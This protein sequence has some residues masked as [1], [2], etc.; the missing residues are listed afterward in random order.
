MPIV[1]YF[2]CSTVLHVCLSINSDDK[3]ID[4]YDLPRNTNREF[5]T[6]EP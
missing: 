3:I 4:K 6:L 1:C 2:D 5:K